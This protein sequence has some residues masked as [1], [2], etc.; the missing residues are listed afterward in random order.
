LSLS[1]KRSRQTAVGG[2]T[3]D[4]SM[5]GLGI[6]PCQFA[7]DRSP[8]VT[9]S[10]GRTGFVV[11]VADA[12]DPIA[13]DAT[14]ASSAT[15]QNKPND[16][17]RLDI[18]PNPSVYHVRDYRS[19]AVRPLAGFAAQDFCVARLNRPAWVDMVPTVR[20]LRTFTS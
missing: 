6:T 17:S 4:K 13:T 9:A 18:E 11:G 12:G 1:F 2:Q 19:S 15:P 10:V 20:C 5:P 7:V 16:L 14:D 3:P 8:E